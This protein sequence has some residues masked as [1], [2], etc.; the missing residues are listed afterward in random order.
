[1]PDPVLTPR[2]ALSFE[3]SGWDT[4]RR[5]GLPS[6]S[7]FKTD[8][9]AIAENN[10]APEAVNQLLAHAVAV[11]EQYESAVENVVKERDELASELKVSERAWKDEMQDITE[12]LLE[13]QHVV[14]EVVASDEEWREVLGGYVSFGY[15]IDQETDP[16]GVRE[17]LSAITTR[18]QLL[19]LL[20]EVTGHY[21]SMLQ[22][23][24]MRLRDSGA[25]AG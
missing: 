6:V 11:R 10:V 13:L 9:L 23:Q 16:A 22:V 15:I 18:E 4:K 21:V 20:L 14:Q 8:L 12:Q 17:R 3:L 1:M 5:E 2:E 24:V 7:E 25:D 19:Q